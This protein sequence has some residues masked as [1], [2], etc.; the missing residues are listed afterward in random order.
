M[1]L[2]RAGHPYA[3]GKQAV[4]ARLSDMP[5]SLAHPRVNLVLAA[6]AGRVDFAD[7]PAHFVKHAFLES[8]G[9]VL[10]DVHDGGALR[11]CLAHVATLEAAGEDDRRVGDENLA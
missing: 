2:G 10:V 8:H 5:E 4:T 9:P 11:A 1:R 3:P 7:R 6:G